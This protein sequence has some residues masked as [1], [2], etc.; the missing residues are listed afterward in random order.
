MNNSTQVDRINQT[1]CSSS[2]PTTFTVVLS[3]VSLLALTRNLLVI[4]TFIRTVN[5]KTSPNYYIVNMAVSDLVCVILNWP[6]Y[7][8]EGM[9]KAGGSLITNPI[10]AKLFCK[11]GIYSRALSYVVS[12]LSLVLIAVDRFVA[13]AFPLKASKIT[14]KARKVFL[15]VCWCLPALGLI[16]YFVYSEIVKIEEQTFCRNMMRHLELKIYHFSG[17]CLILLRTTGFN[18]CPILSYHETFKKKR[19]TR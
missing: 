11:L 10:V 1:E 16:P 8:T 4:T 15:A 13:T 14:G 12:I 17:F 6:L 2:V 5:L 9:L 3:T 7:A 18:C 19:G